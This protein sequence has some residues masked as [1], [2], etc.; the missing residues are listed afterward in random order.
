MT[1]FIENEVNDFE[2]DYEKVIKDCVEGV[3]DHVEFPYE[4]QVNVLITDES[5]IKDINK[6]QRN[7]D[8]STDV[9]SF[10]MI[11]FVNPLNYDVLEDEMVAYDI[12]REEFVLGDIV[13]CEEKI[14]SQA[15]DYGH[16][17]IREMAF[18]VVHSMLH[19]LGYDHNHEKGVEN[20]LT[21]M[22]LEMESLQEE[23]LD[24]LGISR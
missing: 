11:D 17:P 15:K 20:E 16:E 24:K 13:L 1:V 18:L 14:Y 8:K 5:T 7:I 12:D 21:K 19:L 3:L 2:F 22:T 23:I 9:L 4:A 6:E 10:P